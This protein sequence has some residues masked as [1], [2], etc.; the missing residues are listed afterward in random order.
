MPVQS[1]HLVKVTFLINQYPIPFAS[2]S[3]STLNFSRN[4]VYHCR[5]MNVEY[6][7][8]VYMTNLSA[9]VMGDTSILSY[10][11][12]A[13]FYDNSIANLT[14]LPRTTLDAPPKPPSL[15]GCLESPSTVAHCDMWW[16][17]PFDV[18]KCR[19]TST[20]FSFMQLELVGLF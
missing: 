7:I 9:L 12:G 14:K 10:F 1:I 5:H 15:V 18:R 2:C 11:H 3:N 17:E 4:N 13:N 20:S 6:L 19:P 16:Q 8:P